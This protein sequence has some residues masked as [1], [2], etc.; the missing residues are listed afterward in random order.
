MTADE[1]VAAAPIDSGITTFMVG[2]MLRAGILDSRPSGKRKPNW[3]MILDYGIA[4]PKA[5]KEPDEPQF[6]LYDVFPVRVPQGGKQAVVFDMDRERHYGMT[7]MTPH[8]GF[9][10]QSSM[11]GLINAMGG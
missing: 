1:I 9:G 4:E 8:R 7:A 11:M 3:S 10:V 2:S 5:E 6:S